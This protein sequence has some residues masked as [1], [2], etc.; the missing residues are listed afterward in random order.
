MIGIPFYVNNTIQS[1][2]IAFINMKD[3]WHTSINRYM[4]YD[5]DLNN[6]EFLFRQFNTSIDMLDAN[7]KIHRISI[8][9][10]LTKLYNR[11][12]FY[13]FI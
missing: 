12:G 2:L 10:N 13:S 8:T 1:I 6:F 5:T 11:K 3:N 7:N 4:L 9:Y